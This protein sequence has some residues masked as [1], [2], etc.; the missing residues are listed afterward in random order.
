VVV[1][2]RA[3]EGPREA[4]PKVLEETIELERETMRGDPEREAKAWLDKLAD[5]ERMR[6]RLQNMAAN[7]L[8]TLEELRAK[9]AAL[10]KRDPRGGAPAP[11]ILLA[12]SVVSGSRLGGTFQ[13]TRR[14][15]GTRAWRGATG[16]FAPISSTSTITAGCR[17]LEKSS[18]ANR[19]SA[20]VRIAPTAPYLLRPGRLSSREAADSLILASLA[21]VQRSRGASRRAQRRGALRGTPSGASSYPDRLSGAYRALLLLRDERWP[22]TP[23]SRSA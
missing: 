5:V 6:S 1:R 18:S 8:I 16:V 14:P 19:P 7:D 13:C 10:E 21:S 12:R 9:L 3:G 4:A 17:A 2:L 22:L 11:T 15:Q 23:T 20:L